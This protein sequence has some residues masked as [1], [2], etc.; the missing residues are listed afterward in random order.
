MVATD[1]LQ[2]QIR[3]AFA[4]VKYPGDKKL[5]GSDQGDEPFMVEREFYGKNDWNTL[6]PEIRTG[7]MTQAPSED[8]YARTR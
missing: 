8:I 6:S 1:K 2:D 5:R 7:S 4:S 3:A